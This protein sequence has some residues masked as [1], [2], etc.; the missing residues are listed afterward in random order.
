MDNALY[1]TDPFEA[2]KNTQASLITAAFTGCMLL[3]MFLLKW[4]LPTL[5]IQPKEDGILVDLNIPDEPASTVLGGGGGGGNPV[6]AS[7]ERGTAYSPPQQGTN[8]EVKDMETDD[9]DKSTVPVIKPDN[10]KPTATKINDNTASTKVKPK[11][12]VETP[13]P[14]K[15]KAVLGR[16]VGG[17]GKGGGVADN[18]DKSGGSGTGNGV[19]TGSGSGGGTGTGAGGGNGSGSGTGAGPRRVSGNR[20]VINPKSMD[21]GENLRGKVNAEIKVS[22]DGIGTFIRAQKGSTYTSG[23]AIDIIKE[24][25]RRN[26]F[27]KA[28]EES[29][30]VYE[31]NFLLGG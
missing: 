9:N 23:Q 19:G 18:Y 5:P 26:R 11:A 3:L 7:G 27:N 13:A 28:D 15:P 8:E 30:V 25:L 17:T 22:P 1:M 4:P 29:T 2:R 12:V 20:V 14:P 21:A 16:T 31:F 6:Q 24:W 10:P